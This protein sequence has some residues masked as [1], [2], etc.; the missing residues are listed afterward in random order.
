[1]AIGEEAAAAE[2]SFAHDDPA[3]A[4]TLPGSGGKRIKL[5]FWRWVAAG[6]APGWTGAEG[7][8]LEGALPS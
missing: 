1:M 4:G 5:A 7:T 2:G 6:A 3:T 8:W